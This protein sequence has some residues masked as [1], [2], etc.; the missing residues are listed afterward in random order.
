MFW[1]LPSHI[2]VILSL[3]KEL[4]SYFFKNPPSFFFQIRKSLSWLHEIILS[5]SKPAV[6]SRQLTGSFRRLHESCI[7]LELGSAFLK[8]LKRVTYPP[9]SEINIFDPS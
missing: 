9:L 6:I 7:P 5:W 3:V 1:S 2:E 4:R 8:K